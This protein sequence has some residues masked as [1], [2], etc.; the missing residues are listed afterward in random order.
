MNGPARVAMNKQRQQTNKPE[1]Q[2]KHHDCNRLV[3]LS[4]TNNY[5]NKI[6]TQRDTVPNRNE[7]GLLRDANLVW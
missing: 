1:Q 6:Q 5:H 7:I 2:A 4:N 3:N